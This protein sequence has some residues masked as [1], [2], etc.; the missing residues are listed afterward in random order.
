M[1]LLS[2]LL[3]VMQVAGAH[4][5]LCLDGQDAP[6]QVHVNDGPGGNAGFH[7]AAPHQDEVLPLSAQA[8]TANQPSDLAAPPLLPNWNSLSAVS[9]VVLATLSVRAEQSP[10]LVTREALLPPPRGPP[11]TAR[12]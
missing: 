3:L 1:M 6:L 9:T 11:L 12:A 7:S 5:H 2:S 4:L 8:A 10:Y